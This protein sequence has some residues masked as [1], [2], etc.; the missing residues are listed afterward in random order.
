M[1]TNILLVFVLLLSLS[2]YGQE[3][4]FPSAIITAGG[5][6]YSN[7][8]V[9]ISR[10]RIGEVRIVTLPANVRLKE[11]EIAS[12]GISE[13]IPTGWSAQCYPNPAGQFLK[14]R[15]EMEKA[16]R[17]SFELLDATGR[18]MLVKPSEMVLPGTEV[19]FDLSQLTPA[20][21]M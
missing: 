20:L 10:W 13:D 3:V 6:F 19:E 8:P 2:G 12:T 4:Q 15:F 21:Y 7:S 1:R 16:G 14:V 5:S 18:K 11:A 17:F 9:F